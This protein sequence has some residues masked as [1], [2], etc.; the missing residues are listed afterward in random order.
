LR[1]SGSSGESIAGVGSPAALD[2]LFL[3][4]YEELRRIA[5]VLMRSQPPDHTLQPT[6]LVH[7]AYLKLSRHEELAGIDRAHLLALAARAMRQVLVDHARAQRRG[8]RGGGRLRVTLAEN[9]TAVEPAWDVIALDQ[10]LERLERLDAQQV[11]IIELRFLA[12]LPI[13]EVAALLAISPATVK[14][15]TAVARA[16]LFRELRQAT[17]GRGR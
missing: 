7:E 13:E 2:A 3:R 11:K 4:V 10:A 6:S 15:D 1:T 17:G 8:K 9:L 16:W 12:G 5:A 14:R